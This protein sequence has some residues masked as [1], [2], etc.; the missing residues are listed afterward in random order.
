MSEIFEP[1][2]TTRDIVKAHMVDSLNRGLSVQA[3][4]NAALDAN[5]DEPTAR[6]VGRSL[7]EDLIQLG[8]RRAMKKV[9]GG[10][11]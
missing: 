8:K 11:W 4:I 5:L 9:W 3:A 10:V 7:K 1:A 6:S 2:A